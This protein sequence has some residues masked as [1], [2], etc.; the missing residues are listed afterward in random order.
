MLHI[1]RVSGLLMVMVTPPHGA[2]KLKSCTGGFDSSFVTSAMDMICSFDGLFGYIGSSK[3]LLVQSSTTDMTT[4]TNGVVEQIKSLSLSNLGQAYKDGSTTVEKIAR[5][6][7]IRT[8]EYQKKDPA[9]WIH[10]ETSEALMA[11]AKAI[12]DRFAN[13][14][15]PPLYGIPFGVKDN[16]DVAGVRTTAASEAYAY[17]PSKNNPVVDA[18]LDAGALFVGKTNMDQLATGL[19]GCRSPFGSPRSVYGHDRIPGGS[20]SGSS[21]AVGAGLVSFAL[22]TDTAGSGRVPA[23]YNGVVGYKPTLGTL[24]STGSVPACRSLDTLSIL[25]RTVTEARSVW[26]VCDRGPDPTDAYAKST[27]S[28]PT[29]HID[30]RGPRSGGFT[31]GVPPMSVISSICT[32]VYTSLFATAIATLT[33]A[34]GRAVE[35]PWA[36]FRDATDLLYAGSLVLERVACIGPDFFAKNMHTLH[37]VIQDLFTAAMARETKPWDVFKDKIVQQELTAQAARVFDTEMDVLFLPTAPCHP[38]VGEMEMDP[39]RLVSR[40]GA[41]THFANVLDLCA[42]SVPVAVYEAEGT[43]EVLPFG[44]QLIGKGGHDGRVFD[45]AWELEREVG[46]LVVR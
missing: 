8:T 9:V 15:L 42:L 16:I 29:W 43:G 46:E 5:I 13:K 22:G 21:V 12:Q 33:S 34:G 20:S 35:V 41:F 19:S 40:V 39:L 6:V 38:T 17:T 26:L 24:S 11:S 4:T 25:A 3:E 1:E 14:P 32:P 31:F 23:A 27:S 7:A 45:I 10:L 37:P 28:L 44:V 18:L 36:P 30:F 2:D